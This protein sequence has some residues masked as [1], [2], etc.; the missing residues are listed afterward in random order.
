MPELAI[1]R[2]VLGAVMP[3]ASDMAAIRRNRKAVADF[4]AT[5]RGQSAVLFDGSVIATETFKGTDELIRR[6]ARLKRGRRGGVLVKVMK[7]G[8]DMR[9]DIPTIGIGTI[10]NLA[11]GKFDG[12]AV[13]AGKVITEGDRR[14][15]LRLADEKGIFIVGI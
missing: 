14:A 2:G 9:A 12:V 11:A 6:A 8:Q 3:S 13:E 15:L 1:G 7:P 5:D 4:A 10:K